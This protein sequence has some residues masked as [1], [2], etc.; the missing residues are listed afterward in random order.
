MQL[1]NIFLT[2]LVLGQ[3][4][5][6]VIGQVTDPA[7]ISWLITGGVV[8]ALLLYLSGAIFIKKA[9]E[10]ESVKKAML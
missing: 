4:T 2:V 9:E 6:L 10:L 5:N 8:S 3:L 1:A 7:L